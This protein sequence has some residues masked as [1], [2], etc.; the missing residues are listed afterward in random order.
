MTLFHWL[1]ALW[2]VIFKG[3]DVIYDYTVDEK[4]FKRCQYSVSKNLR[5]NIFIKIY[6]FQFVI[7]NLLNF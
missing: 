3:V 5:Y 1:M 2:W 4:E 6:A 7:L